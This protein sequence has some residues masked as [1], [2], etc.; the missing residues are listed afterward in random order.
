MSETRTRTRLTLD[1]SERLDRMLTELAGRNGWSK[2]DA[3]RKGLV[4]LNR[5]DLAKRNGF[6][7][8]ARKQ[9]D[10]RTVEQEIEI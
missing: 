8:T 4:M 9:G 7:V 1:L 5:V 6:E 2:A 10:G 3:L